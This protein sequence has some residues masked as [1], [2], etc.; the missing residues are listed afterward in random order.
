M[1]NTAKDT[2]KDIPENISVDSIKK[3]VVVDKIIFQDK[4]KNYFIL[5]IRD[6]KTKKAFIAKG[7]ILEAINGE[8]NLE[9]TNLLITGNW[10]IDKFGKFFNI[11]KIE[12]NEDPLYFFLKKVVGGLS[13]KIIKNLIEVFGNSTDQLD[14][15]ISKNPRDLELIKGIGPKKRERI[16][17]KWNKFKHIK[18]LYEFLSQY[19]VTVNLC[20]RIYSFFGD[21]SILYIQQNPYCLMFVNNVGF[22]MAD[23][24]AMSMGFNIDSN[25]RIF[26]YWMYLLKQAAESN[27][28]SYLSINYLKQMTSEN[29]NIE[30]KQIDV[31]QVLDV[32]INNSNFYINLDKDI[33]EEQRYYSSPILEA[34]DNNTKIIHSSIK[35]CEEYIYNFLHNSANIEYDISDIESFV[36]DY[37]ESFERQENIILSGQQHNAVLASITRKIFVLT[38]YA[39]T[40]K[41]SISKLIMN[42]LDHVLGLDIVGCAI[43]GI[44]SRRLADKTGYNCYTIHYLL[45]YTA[46]SGFEYNKYNPLPYDVVV[47]DEASMV[48]SLLFYRL[49][50]ALKPDA[51]LIII[52]DAAQLPPIGAG[53][54]FY[55]VLHN[56]I[57]TNVSLT[58]IYRQSKDSVIN[59]RAY[60]IRNKIIPNYK[61]NKKDWFYISINPKVN[62]SKL[63]PDKRQEYR[64]QINT[65]IFDKVIKCAKRFKERFYNN[66]ETYY[67]D[68]TTIND[69]QVLVPFKIG[70][71]GIHAFNQS[72]QKVFNNPDT[73]SPKDKFFNA[74]TGQWFCIGDKVVHLKNEDKSVLLTYNSNQIIYDSNSNKLIWNAGDKN[75]YNKNINNNYIKGVDRIFNGTLGY[76]VDINHEEETAV[77]ITNIGQ[78][79]FYSFSEFGNS[80]NSIVDHAYCLTVHKAQGSEFNNVILPI[81]MSYYAMLNNQWLYTAITRASDKVI[82]IGENYA[83]ERAVKK[84]IQID[85]NSYIDILSNN[86]TNNDNSHNL[87]RKGVEVMN[88]R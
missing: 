74:S 49:I 60:N 76:I 5:N 14:Y 20:N 87:K 75:I 81:S 13:H 70:P 69:F 1:N 19:G 88:N 7:N 85:R 82:I 68:L 55:S 33:I 67:H 51:R 25:Y 73:I 54:V 44:A 77:V 45:K 71:M 36:Y 11:K 12:I 26:A 34:I 39:G 40:G 2:V 43:S 6:K 80:D 46:N 23:H 8:L 35:Y 50:S 31:N 32:D 4:D 28:H 10:K 66:N 83:F 48:N 63:S 30:E 18:D 3:D 79:V 84:D 62:M 52:G 86:S 53:N 58:K 17:E 15:I 37:I 22:K 64:K 38:G 21:K 42:L 56:N 57:S 24:I 78:T 16:V 72:L 65:I 47:L 41:T 27:G 9:K 61:N 59:E 29:L